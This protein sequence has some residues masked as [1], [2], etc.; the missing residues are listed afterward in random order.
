MP[1]CSTSCGT[2]PRDVLPPNPLGSE[3]EE[4]RTHSHHEA[5][6]A[7][8]AWSERHDA[9]SV[10]E[11]HDRTEQEEGTAEV[12]G[13]EHDQGQLPEDEPLD[14]SPSEITLIRCRAVGHGTLP[15]RGQTS[16]T[17]GT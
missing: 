2:S 14:R 4:T 3:E 10:G 17:T 5:D 16:T 7:P 11:R 1:T 8:T 6:R 13:Y 15:S 12:A 9:Q